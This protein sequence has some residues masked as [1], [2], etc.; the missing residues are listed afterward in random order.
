MTSRFRT[1]GNISSPQE[2]ITRGNSK[3]VS[4]QTSLRGA[5]AAFSPQSLT[6]CRRVFEWLSERSKAANEAFDFAK[7]EKK[8]V[9]SRYSQWITSSQYLLQAFNLQKPQQWSRPDAR[10]IMSTTHGLSKF[11]ASRLIHKGLWRISKTQRRH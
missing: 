9:S 8:I 11:I 1:E 3:S 6:T 10:G 5:P 4:W 7:G 2:L